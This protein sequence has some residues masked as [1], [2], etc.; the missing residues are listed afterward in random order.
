MTID[1]GDLPA[2]HNRTVKSRHRKSESNIMTTAR[3]TTFTNLVI[4]I[5]CV[6]GFAAAPAFAIGPG[7]VSHGAIDHAQMVRPAETTMTAGEVRKVDADLGQITIKH[8]DIKNLGMPG[9]TMVFTATNK[10]LLFGLKAGD[11]ITFSAMRE[12]G[13]LMVN[14]IEAVP[15]R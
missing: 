9:M 11:R 4:G 13:K 1:F 15:A 3:H 6:L 2:L 5:S 14:A 7:T 8:A 10:E 12:S